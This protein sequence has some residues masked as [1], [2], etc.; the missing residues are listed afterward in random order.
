MV[1]CSLM[2][3]VVVGRPTVTYTSDFASASS[4]EF[5]DI[6]SARE[7]GLTLNHLRDMIRTYIQMHRTDKYSQRSSITFPVQLNG[8]GFVYELSG[9]GFDCS[10]SHLFFRFHS[11]IK[12]GV[13]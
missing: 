9:C 6:Q 4:K 2:S 10:C 8:R 1:K 5:L 12:D 7:C 11:C 13:P 3:Q